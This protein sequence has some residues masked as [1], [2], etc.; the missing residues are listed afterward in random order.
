MVSAEV[1]I[2]R[3]NVTP[4]EYDVLKYI[5]SDRVTLRAVIAHFKAKVSNIRNT[6]NHLGAIEAI[7]ASD[8][9]EVSLKLTDN[10][11][12]LLQYKLDNNCM[13]EQAK[14]KTK[15]ERYVN[16]FDFDSSP[17]R[18]ARPPPREKTIIPD[19]SPLEESLKKHIAKNNIKI[20]M[21]NYCTRCGKE[22][23][24]S[25]ILNCDNAP[26]CEICGSM[27]R[28][29]VVLYGEGLDGESFGKAEEAIS[30]ADVLIVGG[31][32]RT[33]Q[34]TASLIDLFEGAHLIIINRPPTP[35]DGYAEHVIREPIEDV[36]RELRRA[37]KNIV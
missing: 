18:P 15:A 20:D 22:Y 8:S 36:W 9:G 6:L 33:V 16:P 34:P 29:D 11:M 2:V 24:L 10:Q 32:S 13:G 17:R 25:Y 12:V 31:T 37:P 26:R 14:P 19:I 35:Y 21:R 5:M 28:H 7:E 23:P 3:E 27:V 4:E 1:P 30:E